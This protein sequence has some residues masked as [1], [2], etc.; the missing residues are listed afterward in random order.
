MKNA[1]IITGT[2]GLIGKEILNSLKSKYKLISID[3]NS[4]NDEP[5]ENV[6]H[7]KQDITKINTWH[8]ILKILNENAFDLYGLINCA[9]ITNATRVVGKDLD[10]SFLR[11]LEVN[12]LAPYLAIEILQPLMIKNNFG[13]IINFGSL[14]SKVAPTPR[15]YVGSE[16][17]Q[18]PSYTVSKHGIHGLT[19][20]YA[21]Q[22]IK[23]GITVNTLSPG[24]VF[25]NQDTN[26][27]EK[28]KGQNPSGRMA[29]AQDFLPTINSLLSEENNYL[30]GQNITIDG[31]WTSI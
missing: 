31:G 14:Y 30:T 15:L 23:Y 8:S 28:Y 26:F 10:F 9:A 3:L 2:A 6:L 12:L 29:N 19:K 21:A 18:T 13:R 5:S 7:L 17:L 1:I 4:L 16:V 25:D 20:F 24:G 27:L 22:L 11:T